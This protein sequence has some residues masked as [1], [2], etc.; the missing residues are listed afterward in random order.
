MGR[1]GILSVKR[2]TPALPRVD[3]DEFELADR[4]PR[5]IVWAVLVPIVLV[6]RVLGSNR[7][8]FDCSGV[9]V[10]YS[11]TS[12][13]DYS[14]FYKAISNGKTKREGVET[15]ILDLSPEPDLIVDA[16][17]HFG[18]YTVILAALNPSARVLAYEPDPD[19]TDVCK[20]QINANNFESRVAVR[21]KGVGGEDRIDELYLSSSKISGLNF[22]EDSVGPSLYREKSGADSIQV[23]VDD[24]ASLLKDGEDVFL[25]IDVEGAEEEII[26]RLLEVENR[27]GRIR[28]FV[29]M[30]PDRMSNHSPQELLDRLKER[31]YEIA[32]VKDKN[33][34]RMG[35]YFDSGER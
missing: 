4:V 27:M 5:Q 7:F 13:R 3:M 29:E 20:R 33:P 9:A 23:D 18:L 25:K 28:G 30:H 14:F 17:A 11:Y 31:G 32:T 21:E 26:P 8:S 2:N 12:P 22:F 10:D 19:N 35:Y 1:T 15:D 34:N 16:G 6:G 24:V